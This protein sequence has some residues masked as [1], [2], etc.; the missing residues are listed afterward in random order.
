[1]RGDGR[2]YQ[3]QPTGVWLAS[4]VLFEVQAVQVLVDETKRMCL[5][6]V[7]AHERYYAHPFAVK[8]GPCANF[9]MKPL[10]GSCQ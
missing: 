8:E 2:A 7:N 9:I 3:L 6:R 5:G 1:M 4:Q 10:Q